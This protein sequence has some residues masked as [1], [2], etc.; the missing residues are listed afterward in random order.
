MP[1]AQLSAQKKAEIKAGFA[2]GEPIQHLSRRIGV[3]PNTLRRYRDNPHLL[4]N[5]VEPVKPAP[6]RAPRPVDSSPRLPDPAPEAGGP[7]LP[8]PES[9]VFEDHRID[10]LGAWL[11]I[12]DIH[13]P[14]HDKRAIELAVNEGRQRGIAGI[15]LNGDILD[16]YQISRFSRD[17]S[18]PRVKAEIEKGQQLLEWLRSQFR[19]ARIVFKEGNHDERMKTYLADRAPELFDLDDMQL[20]NL[21]R[22][23]NYGVEWVGDRRTIQLGKLPI[24]H[25]HEYQGSG[26]VMPARWLFIRAWSS[27]LCG[28]FHQP[29]HFPV[30]SLDNR[31][32]SVWSTGCACFLHPYY[33]RRNPWRHGFAMVE[34]STGGGFQVTNRE[35][36]KDGRVV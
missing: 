27:A 35:I 36:L 29:S 7:S 6:R 14:Y 16:F 31:E 34:I 17:P 9:E 32:M 1:A 25:G 24:I 30:T 2:V 5:I 4:D 10:T 22:A 13:L 20:P 33:R 23:A 8:E 18:R 19:R 3:T 21:L 28:H 12:S 26:G 11:V 15:I